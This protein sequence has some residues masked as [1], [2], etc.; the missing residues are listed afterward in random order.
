M[1]KAHVTHAE[2]DGVHVLRYSGK[3]DYMSAPIRPA[4]F[5]ELFDRGKVKG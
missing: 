2:C 1:A 4:V 5:D 3:V